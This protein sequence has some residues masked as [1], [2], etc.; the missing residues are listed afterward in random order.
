[1]RGIFPFRL[2]CMLARVEPKSGYVPWQVV[3]YCSQDS[4]HMSPY[5][6]AN[7]CLQFPYGANAEC[8]MSN[9]NSAWYFGTNLRVIFTLTISQLCVC[10]W[11]PKECLNVIVLLFASVFFDWGTVSSMSERKKKCFWNKYKKKHLIVLFIVPLTSGA[12][13]E[14][15]SLKPL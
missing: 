12:R 15:N 13:E 8:H 6:N 14:H 4:S 11:Q 10:H 1:M 7:L 9:I 2:L 3:C 5:W